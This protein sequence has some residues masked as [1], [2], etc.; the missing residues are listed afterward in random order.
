MQRRQK[1]AQG[2]ERLL[3]EGKDSSKTDM[4]EA[5]SDSDL[6]PETVDCKLT[7]DSEIFTPY[8]LALRIFGA[9][10]NSTRKWEQNWYYIVS[11]LLIW[12]AKQIMEP[13]RSGSD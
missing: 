1:E 8:R 2:N 3:E 7:Y 11:M 10:K 9:T 13:R 5:D 12:W 4:C 6:E